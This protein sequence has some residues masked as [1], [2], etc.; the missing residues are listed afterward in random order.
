MGFSSITGVCD[1]AKLNGKKKMK[2]VPV[3]KLG[4]FTHVKKYT[5]TGQLGNLS[6]PAK[7]KFTVAQ[8]CVSV[9]NKIV[10]ADTGHIF[11]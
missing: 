5:G 11:P 3:L 8:T 9:L 10:H 4:S 2:E 7:Y 6:S 1:T